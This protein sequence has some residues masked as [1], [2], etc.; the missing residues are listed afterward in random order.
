MCEKKIYA[1]AE[2]YRSLYSDQYS[3]YWGTLYN[4]LEGQSTEENNMT[5]TPITHNRF[6]K[7]AIPTLS[8]TNS[9][10]KYSRNIRRSIQSS[11]V[12]YPC[13]KNK[14]YMS[15]K[16]NSGQSAIQFRVHLCNL[17]S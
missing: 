12:S 7:S 1:Y 13:T 10:T 15:Y 17:L 16:L 8:K 3:V 6:N 4:F 9:K 5:I 2:K 14:T 11:L